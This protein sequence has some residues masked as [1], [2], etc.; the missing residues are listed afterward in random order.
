MYVCSHIHLIFFYC[1]DSL[2]S[3][4]ASSHSTGTATPAPHPTSCNTQS[5]ESDNEDGQSQGSRSSAGGSLANSSS[6]I[7]SGRDIDQ[8]NR[9]S[10]PS[11]SGSPLAS[12]DSESDSPDS[13]KQG[14]KVK[15]G[16]V[17]KPGGAGRGNDSGSG[18][19]RDTEGVKE[20]DLSV[21]K[22]PSSLCALT[23]SSSARKSYF[24]VDPKIPPKME[25]SS[26]VGDEA[27]H[28]CSRSNVNPK[29]ASH[30]G[31]KMVVGGA[32]YPHGNPNVSHV[33]SS[34]LPPPPALKPLEAGQS[35]PGDI[36][37][38]KVEKCDKAPPSLLPQAT[39]LPQQTPP[40]RHTHHY[41]PTAW[42]GS[43]V[44]T[45]PG[46]WG[47]TRYPGV[48]HAPVQQQQ[49]PSVYNPPSSTR[50]SS[51]PP[52]LSHPHP[53]HPHREYLPRYSSPAERDRATRDIAI[54]D[55]SGGSGGHNNANM[56][57]D[58]VTPAPGQNREFGAPGRDGP[59]G[60]REFRPGFR[61][62]DGLRDFSLQNQNQQHIAQSRDFGPGGAS[63][64]GG[65]GGCHPR[66][67]EGR[68]GEFAGQMREVVG[69][70]N[71][72]NVNQVNV[73]TS[74]SSLPSNSPQNSS[75]TPNKDFQSAVEQVGQGHQGQQVPANGSDPSP[76]AHFL[77]EYTPPETKEYP[78]AGTQPSSAPHPGPSREFPSPTRLPSNM[79]RDFAGGPALPHPHY[80]VQ[81]G[82]TVQ[83][84]ER[85]REKERERERD[86]SAPS[87]IYH[88]RNHPPSLSPSSSSSTH[89]HQPPASYTPTS[90]SQ[91]PLP[92][93]T[94]PP[95]QTRPGQYPSSNQSPPTTLSPLP[96]PSANQIGGFPPFSSTTAPSAS[97]AVTSCLS[98]SRQ[99]PYH[100]TLN[101]HTPFAGA[102]HGN[103]NHSSTAATSNPNSNNSVNSH[104]QL[105]SPTPSK[106][107][108]HLCNPVAPPTNAPTGAEAQAESSSCS[109]PQ[110]VIKE[111][112]I[113]EREE[114]ASPP[115]V[116]RS[117][118]PEPKAIDIPIH[119]SQ[120]AR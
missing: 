16:V 106:I 5:R 50:H 1:K 17:P 40:P 60:G 100:G 117:P 111:E 61:E 30:C 52:Y 35:A 75:A 8:D 25:F 15:E 71:S 13:P 4:P 37:M 39:S 112:P 101:S 91:Q 36:K 66:D 67:K 120:S 68:W 86:N 48:H 47:Y 6:S 76:T 73:S 82:L 118:S 7:S 27:L 32:E 34:A 41:S 78:P 20:A 31:G 26:V 54:K 87:S 65:S 81:T 55:G 18:E 51:H 74:S 21:L 23:E 29:T 83:S 109:L 98:G 11:L 119:A 80:L 49:L 95:S 44:S 97:G 94:L 28:G 89:G 85:E 79:G 116:L 59:S 33:S 107:Q 3:A 38:E 9:S 56:G 105:H 90:H 92:P 10:S 42:S 62:R 114:T 93:S 108:P 96:S 72:S 88:N 70:S 104:M 64:T 2:S 58:F 110:P 12:L 19:C 45:C 57:S 14:G 53:P 77:R 43:A 102:Y 69:N 99:A 63:G 115:S 84:R 24:S 103:T 22:S 46:N 113:E